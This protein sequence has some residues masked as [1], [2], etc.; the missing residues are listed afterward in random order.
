V[1]AG[2]GFTSF[3]RGNIMKR[4]LLAV[5]LCAFTATPA[6]AAIRLI[7]R[8]QGGAL[9]LQTACLLLGCSVQYPLGDDQGQLFLVAVP[10]NLTANLLLNVPG[11]LDI[12][13]DSVG[14]TTGAT[15]SGVPA[16]LYDATPVNYY[17]TTV[18]EG[19]VTQPAAQI[20]GLAATQ[21][22][23]GVR[24]TGTVA[25]IDTGVDST[26]P[27]LAGALVPGYDFT[28]NQAGA[29]D[30]KGDISQSTTA[31]IDQSTTAVVDQST[32]AVIDQY[33]AAELNQPQYQAFGHG[34][35]VS[36]VVRLTA[37]G[38]MIM[39]LKA[40]HADGTGYASDVIRAIYF[41]VHHQA[42]VLNMSFSF[43]SSSL[44]LQL[45]LTYAKL[46]G[47]ISVAAA[48]N[49]GRQT[50]VYPAGYSGTVMG[51]AS[52]SNSDT[53]ST[54]SNYGQNLVW[55]GAP[56]EGVVTLYPYG[57]YAATWGTSFSAPFVA[58]AAALLLDVQPMCG[59][60]QAAQAM[61]HA[62]Y[63]NSYLGNGRLDLYQAVQ[64]WRQA[65]GLQ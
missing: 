18:R 11:V 61:S 26:H 43:P 64:A 16:A 19:Y 52:T 59:E 58:G 13:I 38:A 4:I 9:V 17:G 3:K 47:V 28:R 46:N 14:E 2:V 27:A 37:P 10:L 31:V 57:T 8:V 51:V 24:G 12:E 65:N 23:F 42:R 54:F 41:A 6:E 29:A 53:L 62:K 35:M 32:T 25:V 56:G 7:V 45:A 40:F 1:R 36:G 44:E 50:M 60:S 33:T 63:I 39:P 48:G 30:E 21:N 49:D 20:I 5:L 15:Q 34:T 22:A 55:V